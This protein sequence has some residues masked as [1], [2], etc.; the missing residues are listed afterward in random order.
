[1]KK[2]A[3]INDISGLGRCS[4]SAALPVIS[5]L[6]AQCCPLPTGVFSAQT[7]YGRF[8]HRDLTDEIKPIAESWQDLGASFDAVLTG[9]ITDSRQGAEILELIM[10]FKSSGALIVV[11]PVMG[12]DGKIYPCYDDESVAAVRALAAEADVITPNLTELC[13]L[14]GADAEKAHSLRG[15]ALFDEVFRL[16]AR[17]ASENRTVITTGLDAG[18]GK[19]GS[20]VLSDSISHV[21]TSQK[22]GG[23]FSGTGDI[24]TSIVT[25]RLAC[26][27]DILDAVNLAADFISVCA[28]D[29]VERNPD[30]DRNDGIE[31][32]RF[33]SL[34]TNH[35]KN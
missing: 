34:L 5:A 15:K 33:L 25:A 28:K 22:F 10:L 24:F 3:V 21:Y 4:L 31:F 35:G 20:T 14:A 13:L 11:D 30:Y 2:V 12:D 26:G 23:S 29:T 8:H 9:F 17:F 6:G 19:I 27:G 32:E 16:S 1:M 18:E 7:G